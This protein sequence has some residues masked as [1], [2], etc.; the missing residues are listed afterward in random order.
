MC[1]TSN[2]AADV[3]AVAVLGDDAGGV[4]APACRSR[5]TA[6]SWRRVRGAGRA[7]GCSE[8]GSVGH[9]QPPGAHRGPVPTGLAAGRPGSCPLC[10]LYLRDWRPPYTAR[11]LAPS[12]GPLEA[13]LSPAR[14]ALRERKRLPVLLPERSNRFSSCSAP[15][16]ASRGSSLLTAR[17][18]AAAGPDNRHH[19]SCR[20]MVD[21]RIAR[22]RSAGRGP[23]R[24]RQG[25]VHRRRAA[26]RRGAG[27]ACSAAR[28][29]GSRP[30]DRACAAKARSACGPQCRH[31][32]TCGGCKMQHLHVAARRWRPSSA[33]SKT[34][35]GTW[36]R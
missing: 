24:R 33:R 12:V 18:V 19:D 15:S 14:N 23:Q 9:G 1:E 13:G 34:R 4:A 6:P 7:A 27:D 30:H 3:A 32:G 29:T 20:R 25:G 31:F 16:A 28:T 22:P 2:S 10:P 35:S 5:Q 11:P 17:S 8:A 21:G 26:G 36:A